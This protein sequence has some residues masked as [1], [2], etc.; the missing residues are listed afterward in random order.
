[1]AEGYYENPA[2]DINDWDDEDDDDEEQE[3]NRTQPFQPGVASTPYH[4]GEEIEM[5]TSEL[6]QTGLPDIS[7]EETT[8][9][10]LG[11]FIR[12]HEE[13]KPDKP[14][15]L[16]RVKDLIRKKRARVDFVKLPPIGFS[17]K[18]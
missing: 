7:Y 5:Q 13:D 4:G 16:K 1:M 15:R 18:R 6:E 17:K 10:L 11:D 9:P 3:V 8:A 12:R 2:F 14:D